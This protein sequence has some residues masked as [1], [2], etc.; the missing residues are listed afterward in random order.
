MYFCTCSSLIYALC[1]EPCG[2]RDPDAVE[3]TNEGCFKEIAGD[4]PIAHVHPL[5]DVDPG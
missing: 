1:Q 5:D 4:I 2:Y 3:G